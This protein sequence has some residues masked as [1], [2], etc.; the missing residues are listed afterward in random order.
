[1]RGIA[2]ET[3]ESLVVL[4]E[5]LEHLVER[6][7]QVTDLVAALAALHACREVARQRDRAGRI[8]DVGNRREGTSGENEPAGQG[9]PDDER[10]THQQRGAHR[11]QQIPQRPRGIRPCHVADSLPA[12]QEDPFDRQAEG[13]AVA[14]ELP[15]GVRMAIRLREIRGDKAEDGRARRCGVGQHA[16]AWIEHDDAPAG[17][18]K[19]VDEPLGRPKNAVGIDVLGECAPGVLRIGEKARVERAPQLL[20][21]DEVHAR[22]ERDERG[23]EE[24]GVDERQP[25]PDRPSWW[26][27]RH[28]LRT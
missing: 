9:E 26:A 18:R 5:R 19:L 8:R 25:G 2:Q 10:A 17:R 20:A 22:T 16:A 1:M 27:K 24:S 21:E 14:G 7:R 3:L 11:R 28:S 23:G 13:V 15:D 12:R 4:F 6:D